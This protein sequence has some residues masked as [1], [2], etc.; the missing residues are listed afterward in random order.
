[1]S[2]KNSNKICKSEVKENLCEVSDIS[3]EEFKTNYKF[4]T[5]TA[6]DAYDL[7][8]QMEIT[9]SKLNSKRERD[10]N[11]KIRKDLIE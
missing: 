3:E 7:I 1:M 10:K 8:R 4:I 5:E 11:F 2:R 9:I 6:K